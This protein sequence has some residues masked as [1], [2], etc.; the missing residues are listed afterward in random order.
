MI[1]QQEQNKVWI[2]MIIA[3]SVA[4]R[5]LIDTCECHAISLCDR[6]EISNTMYTT[7]RAALCPR[8]G[9]Q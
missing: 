3:R 1:G 5:L 6:Y 2:V 9:N 7:Y 4:V 8:L